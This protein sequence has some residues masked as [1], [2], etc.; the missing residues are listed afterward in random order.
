MHRPPSR[1]CLCKKPGLDSLPCSPTLFPRS[2]I[3]L[4]C[5]VIRLGYTQLMV[6]SRQRPRRC[7]RSGEAVT[8]ITGD[9]YSSVALVS[10]CLL[11]VAPPYSLSLTVQ[12][13]R[14][15]PTNIVDQWAGGTYS[16]ALQIGT[17]EYVLRVR[18]LDPITLEVVADRSPGSRPPAAAPHSGPGC[19]SIRSAPAGGGRPTACPVVQHFTRL[20]SSA[21]RQ[22]FRDTGH[23]RP[24]SAGEP[25]SGPELCEPS[26]REVWQIARCRSGCSRRPR[27]S[28]THRSRTCALQV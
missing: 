15:V 9:R 4:L 11:D 2:S 20:T 25:R 5:F 12:V 23:D 21:L 27:Q 7:C 17:E 13:L 1:L 28:R 16:R 6:R 10:R 18:Q 24:V 14:R 19:R 22:S 3:W 26:G 8:W